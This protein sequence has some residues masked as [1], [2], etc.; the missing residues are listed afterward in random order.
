MTFAYLWLWFYCVI[1]RSRCGIFRNRRWRWLNSLTRPH[2]GLKHLRGE[3]SYPVEPT[4]AK[5]SLDV[6]NSA[7]RVFQNG[8]DFRVLAFGLLGLEFV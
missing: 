7:I 6:A 3:I 5:R 4:V 1:C 8:D 2:A